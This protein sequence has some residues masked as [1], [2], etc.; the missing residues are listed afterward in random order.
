VT[1]DPRRTIVAGLSGGGTAAAFAA[2]RRPDLF[3]NVLAQSGAFWW[4][5]EDPEWLARQFAHAEKAPLRFY[6]EAGRMEN[7]PPVTRGG[8]SLLVANRHL[9]DVLEAKGYAVEYRENSGG[10]DVAW[11]RGTLADGLQ[12]LAGDT[13][14]RETTKRTGH[15]TAQE[16]EAVS[17][18]E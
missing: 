16:R 17:A 5:S 7:V 11:W 9:R 8:P 2:L 3:G 18:S 15:I 12:V 6:L 4:S 1:T 10:H 14:G 13:A